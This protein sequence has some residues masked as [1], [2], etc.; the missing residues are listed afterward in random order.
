MST[1]LQKAIDA[2]NAKSVASLIQKGADPNEAA[3]DEWTPLLLVIAGGGSSYVS[4]GFATDEVL[5][6]V[7]LLIDRGARVDARTSRGGT[8]V[9]LA[10]Q[11]C[12]WP[13]V[14]LL[15]QRG[16]PVDTVD[17]AGCAP[18][19][20]AAYFGAPPEVL[21]ALLAAGADPALATAKS[22]PALPVPRGLTAH[23]LAKREKHRALLPLLEPGTRANAKPAV[24]KLDDVLRKVSSRW[25]H[26]SEAP[27]ELATIWR[28]ALDG[29]A[30]W[31]S[32]DVELLDDSS[33]DLPALMLSKNKGAARKALQALFS[34]LRFVATAED[35]GL[36]AYWDH[37]RVPQVIF[38]DNEGVAH[39]GA[40]TLAEALVV[41][42]EDPPQARRLFKALKLPVRATA[43]LE[44]DCAALPSPSPGT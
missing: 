13:V 35:G 38:V 26:D 29:N 42:A 24:R 9:S 20:L 10:V 36:F 3:K 33:E 12:L 14:S 8:A 41:R 2:R 28:A 25:L 19:H 18:L 4:R 16:A 39:R 34:Q 27:A 40:P 6:L 23:A 11:H 31:A 44:K 43:A 32:L 21:A 30:D 1:P 7:T 5:S 37:P 17:D 22:H 15:V